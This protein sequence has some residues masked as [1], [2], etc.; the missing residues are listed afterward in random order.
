M[1]G[2]L[3]SV[4]LF[5]DDIAK[6]SQFYRH[7]LG[8]SL[9]AQHAPDWVEFETNGTTLILHKRVEQAYPFHP[10]LVFAV[11][12]TDMAYQTLKENG[13]VFRHAPLDQSSGYRSAFCAD[14]D[15]NIVKITSHTSKS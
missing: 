1:L 8:L 4:V 10:E 7:D 14:P 6:S 13:V 15:G 2:K 9:K 12:D 3:E 5:V 11:D